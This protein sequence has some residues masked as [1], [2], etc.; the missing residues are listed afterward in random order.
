M[1]SKIKN[2]AKAVKDLAVDVKNYNENVGRGY[3]YELMK[4]QFQSWNDNEIIDMKKPDSYWLRSHKAKRSKDG[5]T[6]LVIPIRH[7]TRDLS[8]GVYKE[9]KQMDVKQQLLKN[10][11]A[12]R[13]LIAKYGEEVFAKMKAHHASGKIEGLTKVKR[14]PR[15]RGHHY[16]TFR[17][18]STKS[19]RGRWLLRRSDFERIMQQKLKGSQTPLR[20]SL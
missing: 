3:T 10:S 20:N 4:K 9:A 15:L 8:S 14:I 6:Y 18:L 5:S 19:P 17:V 7:K 13:R 11:E 16:L 1:L 2:F 12:G